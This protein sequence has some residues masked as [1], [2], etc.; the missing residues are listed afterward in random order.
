M[1]REKHGEGKKHEHILD[2]WTYPCIT[3]GNKIKNQDYV[4]LHWLYKVGSF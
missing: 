1:R 2:D 3:I 4:P